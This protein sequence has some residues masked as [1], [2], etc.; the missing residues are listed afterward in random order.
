MLG[1]QLAD[2]QPADAHDR[3]HRQRDDEVRAEPVVLL[4]LVEHDL[5]AAD[6][7]DQQAD[8][9]VVDASLL[10]MPQIRRI[11]DENLRQDDRDDADG[12][13]D[14]EDP[15]P[16]VIVGEPA[17]GDRTEHGRDHDAERPERHRL[18]ALLRRKR[19]QQD[20][21]RQRLQSA[22]ARA[23]NDAADNEKRQVRRQSAEK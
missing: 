4:S 12:N 10:A 17:A 7:D 16:T 14:V 8:A 9:P 21:L 2:D 13:V 11:E 6:A 3:E 5:Q 19:L 23:L 20:G 18:P 15:A 22:A 1:R